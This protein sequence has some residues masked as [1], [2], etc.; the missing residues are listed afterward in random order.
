MK[1]SEFLLTTPVLFWRWSI[2]FANTSDRYSTPLSIAISVQYSVLCEKTGMPIA[3]PGSVIPRTEM[4]RINRSLRTNFKRS[5]R[6]EK[7]G[8]RK[9]HR[10]DLHHRFST[11]KNQKSTR[12]HAIYKIFGHLVVAQNSLPYRMG[13]PLVS[14]QTHSLK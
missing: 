2:R 10:S 8:K 13:L 6:A 9:S 14:A 11:V 7:P 3:K 4:P 1:T 5:R 12:R